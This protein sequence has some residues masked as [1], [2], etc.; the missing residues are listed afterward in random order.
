MIVRNVCVIYDLDS[1]DVWAERSN[2]WEEIDVITSVEQ[3]TDPEF[4]VNTGFTNFVSYD[5]EDEVS[6]FITSRQI[7]TNEHNTICFMQELRT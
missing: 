3:F 2:E 1:K 5:D 4:F 6:S 7:R